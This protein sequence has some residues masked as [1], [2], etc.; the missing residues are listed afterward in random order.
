M[1]YDIELVHPVNGETLKLDSNHHMRGGTYCVGG[2]DEARLNVTYNYY[3][4]FIRVL[5]D[6]GIRT[7]YGMSG[8]DSIP[9]LSNA[10]SQLADDVSDN[11]WEP[12]EGNAKASLIQLLTLAKMRPDGIWNGD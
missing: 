2:T 6:K 7:I 10:V 4:H 12:T 1:S 3:K 8:V 9:V 5:G 11:Y